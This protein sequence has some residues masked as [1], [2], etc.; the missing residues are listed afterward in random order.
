MQTYPIRVLLVVL[1]CLLMLGPGLRRIRTRLWS[2]RV[3][4]GCLR[5]CRVAAAMRDWRAA[6]VVMVVEHEQPSL[7]AL[8][9]QLVLP[10]WVLSAA[11]T[12]YSGLDRL[13]SALAGREFQWLWH[14]AP[15]R[16]D[17]EQLLL[18]SAPPH[19]EAAP[20]ALPLAAFVRS[21][22]SPKVPGEIGHERYGAMFVLVLFYLG[23]L[24]QLTSL[25]PPWLAVAAF[26][27]ASVSAALLDFVGSPRASLEADALVFRPRGLLGPRV[28]LPKARLRRADALTNDWPILRLE[29]TNG[30]VVRPVRPTSLSTSKRRRRLIAQL[31]RA[32]LLIRAWLRE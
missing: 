10:R 17:G 12:E 11:S 8:R 2:I 3:Q 24:W 27:C 31:D 25:H 23:V 9:L 19:R 4:G 22:F 29:M 32:T 15:S 6:D 16:L 7:G 1:L 26:G 30:E 20:R 18:D 13:R 5:L 21:A 28:A 14:G